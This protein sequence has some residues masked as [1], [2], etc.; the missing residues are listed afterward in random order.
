MNADRFPLNEKQAAVLE[1]ARA[2][3]IEHLERLGV[4]MPGCPGC[5]AHYTHYRTLWRPGSFGPEGPSH[6][7]SPRCMSGGHPHCSCG[8]CF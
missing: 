6:T 4:L 8:V 3:R 7:A 1:A 2:E 5:A